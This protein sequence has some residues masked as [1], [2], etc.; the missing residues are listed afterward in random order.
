MGRLTIAANLALIGLVAVGLAS[1]RDGSQVWAEVVCLSGDAF[2]VLALALALLRRG[3]DGWWLGFALFGWG[4]LLL[5]FAVAPKAPPI[6][7]ATRQLDVLAADAHARADPLPPRPPPWPGRDAFM[8][9]SL[10]ER[11]RRAIKSNVYSEKSR[12]NRNN[13]RWRIE[14]TR[15]IGHTWI[16]LMFGSLGAMLGAWLVRRRRDHRVAHAL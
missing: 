7:W 16:G 13:L 4:Y 11:E 8:K 2:L 1:L 15:R 6:A 14:Q 5:A 3:R 12:I 9:L 10:E